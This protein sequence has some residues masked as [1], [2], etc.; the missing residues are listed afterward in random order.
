MH[1]TGSQELM[2]MGTAPG[3]GRQLTI[4]V[5]CQVKRWQLRQANRIFNHF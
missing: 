3:T 4:H 2:F 1:A 5:T